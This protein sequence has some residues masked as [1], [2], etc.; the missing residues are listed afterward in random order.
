MARLTVTDLSLNPWAGPKPNSATAMLAPRVRL[1]WLHGCGSP[2]IPLGS[3][4]PNQNGTGC[5]Q[6]FW[7]TGAYAN[8]ADTPARLGRISKKRSAAISCDSAVLGLATTR[9]MRPS[10]RQEPSPKPPA[11]R[12][13]QLKERPM[14][15]HLIGWYRRKKWSCGCCP[16]ARPSR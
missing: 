16:T 6:R 12:T 14:G 5:L 2:A 1:C 4:Q 15:I 13:W 11:N 7:Q 8:R 9:L 3:R 10:P